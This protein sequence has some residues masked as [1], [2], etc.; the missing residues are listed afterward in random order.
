MGLGNNLN[1]FFKETE[2][3]IDLSLF[4]V[5]STTGLIK[6][7]RFVSPNFLHNRSFKV[8]LYKYTPCNLQHTQM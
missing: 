3:C 2:R 4:K 7:L 6:H 1:L 5:D 8:F